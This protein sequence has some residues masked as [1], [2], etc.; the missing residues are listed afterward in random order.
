[1]EKITQ[2]LMASPLFAF[3]AVSIEMAKLAFKG[4]DIKPLVS[5][6]VDEVVPAL[7]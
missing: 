2:I 6:M 1:M 7:A 5:A 3:I 4:T